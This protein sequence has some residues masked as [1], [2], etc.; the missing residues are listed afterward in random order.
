MTL[1]KEHFANVMDDKHAIEQSCQDESCTAA[2]WAWNTSCLLISPHGNNDFIILKCN[3]SFRLSR[4]RKC[5][6]F[7]LS[8]SLLY[9]SARQ[10][11]KTGVESLSGSRKC[12]V[13]FYKQ[14]FPE[15]CSF[16]S[17]SAFL[18]DNIHLLSLSQ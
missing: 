11:V 10:I 12:P 4:N 3:F 15:M 17:Q 2:V 8:L 5:L 1:R 6:C 14:I 9:S 13:I 18:L 7:S 16:K